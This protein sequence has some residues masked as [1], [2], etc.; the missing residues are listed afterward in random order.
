MERKDFSDA[1]WQTLVYGPLWAYLAVAAQDGDLA[2]QERFAFSDAL[3]DPGHMTGELSREVVASLAAAQTATFDSWQADDRSLAD[4]FAA[5][6][7]IL[8]KVGADEANRYKGTLV[9]LAVKVA[10]AGSWLGGDI[11]QKERAAIES[12]A[13]ML[14][15]NVTD[16]VMATYVEDVLEALPR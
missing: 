8:A 7:K 10:H 2:D 13:E 3:A 5:I 1:E 9:W 12:L 11:S 14:D 6:S 4:G 16:A 15:F